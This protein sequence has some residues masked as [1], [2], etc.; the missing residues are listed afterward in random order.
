M[1]DIQY[2]VY[3]PT[4]THTHIQKS[5]LNWPNLKTVFALKIFDTCKYTIL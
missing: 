4:Q 2:T 1:G 3:S 5:S